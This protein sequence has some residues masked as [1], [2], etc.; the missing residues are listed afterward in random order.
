MS[1]PV[2]RRRRPESPLPLAGIDANDYAA[3]VAPGGHGPVVNLF[4]HRDLDRIPLQ[5]DDAGRA[6]PGTCG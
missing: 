3:V 4:E 2:T 6:L 5:T 1:R